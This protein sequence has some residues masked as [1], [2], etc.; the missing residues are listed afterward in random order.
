[1][2]VTVEKLAGKIGE[3]GISISGAGPQIQN[4]LDALPFYVILVDSDHHIVAVN[5]K[6]LN[7][8]KVT[9]EQLVGAYCPSAIHK[10]NSPIPECPLMGASEKG[11]PVERELFDAKN[12]R[13]M[14]TAAFPTRLVNED[15]KPVFLHFVR[16]ITEV[17]KIEE[18]LSQSAERYSAL[19]ALLQRF[20]YCQTSVQILDTLIDE[21]ASLSWLG[22]TSTAAGFLVK[23]DQLE[24]VS[25]HNLQPDQRNL[26]KLVKF[27][28]CLCGKVAQTGQSMICS[29]DSEEHNFKYDGMKAHRHTVLPI[30]HEGRIF[31]VVTFYLKTDEDINES[32]MDFLNAAVAAAAA[33]FVGQ[34]AR[35]EVKLIQEKSMAQVFSWQEE[36]RK[37][38][39]RELHDQVCQSLSALLLEIQSHG[40][41]DESLRSI[42]RGCEARVRD[43][44]DEV[45]RM[46]GQLRP[47]ILDD[48]GLR[49]ALSRH[50]EELSSKTGL[51]IDYQYVA[52]PDPSRRLPA[53]IEVG[54][55]RIAVAAL[56]N[57]A[58]HASASRASVI[59]LWQ[60]SKLTFLVED[61]G[62]GFDYAATRKNLDSCIGLIGMEERVSIMGGV[63]RI[64]SAPQKGTTIR[65]EIPVPQ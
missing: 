9:S 33:A 7:D 42:Q 39:S 52:S 62:R 13:W 36:E 19:C 4:V 57:I 64:E 55:Y 51:E 45:S 35:E 31:G 32:R 60:N 54:L 41:M 21:V 50:I 18:N 40:S 24:M 6:V 61:D 14:Q 26:C 34:S 15:G 3:N 5:Q 30:S 63:L 22:V 53:P 48:Y 49:M 23:D 59:I 46:A 10:C 65:A 8:F 20:Q 56:D 29:S 27:G 16:D 28:E 1:V 17:K 38:I 44:I 58:I 12:A 2:K 37:R 47:T 11:E 43:L 25:W